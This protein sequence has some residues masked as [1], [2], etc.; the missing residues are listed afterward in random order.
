MAYKVKDEKKEYPKA[1]AGQHIGLCV[2]FIGPWM[3]V[4][5]Y[6]K[7]KPYPI[8]KVAYV[9]QLDETREDGKPFEVAREFS[10]TFGKKANLRKFIG[11]WRGKEIT[12]E[13]AKEG[14]DIDFTGRPGYLTLEHKTTRTGNLRVEVSTIMPLPKVIPTPDALPYKRAEWWKKRID[15]DETKHRKLGQAQAAAQAKGAANAETFP[16]AAGGMDEF[17]AALAADDDEDSLPF[18]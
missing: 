16:A 6:D 2:D 4:D 13:E 1:S 3:A 14:V 11:G 10:L 15:E 12:D 5:D 7:D 9:W 8:Q 17:P 18:S